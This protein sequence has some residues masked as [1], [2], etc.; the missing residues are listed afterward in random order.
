MKGRALVR[1]AY[2]LFDTATDLSAAEMDAFLD[3][4]RQLQA[5]KASMSR[6]EYRINR[7][8]LALM[9]LSDALDADDLAAIDEDAALDAAEDAPA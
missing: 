3:S 9:L 8:V 2:T 5:G 6:K 7:R 4:L 1:A